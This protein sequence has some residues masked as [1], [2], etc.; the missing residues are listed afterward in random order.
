MN[1]FTRTPRRIGAR[2]SALARMILLG[3]WISG[4][5]IES[6]RLRF[7]MTRRTRLTTCS[8]RLGSYRTWSEYLMGGPS[9]WSTLSHPACD[10]RRSKQRCGRPS[11]PTP[12]EY[13]RRWSSSSSTS[14]AWTP[15]GSTTTIPKLARGPRPSISAATRPRTSIR[16]RR[17]PPTG[18]PTLDAR[19]RAS[20]FP[21]PR[22]APGPRDGWI[23]QSGGA[24]AESERI[25]DWQSALASDC[26]RSVE[27]HA[28]DSLALVLPLW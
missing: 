25:A 16:R 26:D 23:R 28:G 20:R 15:P 13:R 21:S 12:A 24:V 4:S 8:E 7:A 11:G 18:R 9:V 14:R 22:P 6:K 2:L 10:A 1:G 5:R 17:P 27:T 3:R 19:P